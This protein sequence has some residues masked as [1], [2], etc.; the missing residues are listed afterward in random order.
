MFQCVM[1]MVRLSYSSFSRFLVYCSNIQVENPVAV[2][3]QEEAKKFL[4]GKPSDKYSFFLKA[5]ELERVDR[6]YSATMDTLEELMETQQKVTQSLAVSMERVD[7]LRQKYEQHRELE[8]LEYKVQELSLK[9]A[10]SIHGSHQERHESAL[11]KLSE[12]KEKAEAKQEELTQAEE[13]ANG[14]NDEGREKTQRIKDLSDE[15]G[16]QADLKRN[17]EAQLKETTLPLK[18][19]QRELSSFQK[20]HQQAN[21]AVADAKAK[22]QE[23]RE[24]LVRQSG[25]NESEEAQRAEALQAAEAELEEAKSIVDSLKQKFS[26]TRKAA[27]EAETRVTS[28]RQATRSVEQQLGSVER[29]LEGLEASGNNSM[30]VF[31]PRVTKVHKMIE[32]GKLS[33]IIRFYEKFVDLTN[34]V[35]IAKQR[36]MFRGPVEGP[37]GEFLKISAG[38]E[39]FA[40]IG[41]LALGSG[42]LDRFVV[43][44][45]A[46]RKLVQGIRRKCG[47]LQDCGIFQVHRSNS[48][49]NV[50]SPPVNGIETV[51][52]AFSIES[53]LIFNCLVDN[54]RIEKIALGRSKDDSQAKLLTTDANGRAA[55]RGGKI[56]Q[57]YFM[58]K[59]DMWQVRGGQ[60][61]LISNERRMR[62]T[63]S[64]DKSEAIAATKRE[65]EQLGIELDRATKEE[66][67]WEGEHNKLTKAWNDANRARRSNDK[68]MNDLIAQIDQIK[69]E[70]ENAVPNA[71]IDTS[72][73]EDGK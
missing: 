47:C 36:R 56:A 65:I 44:N 28:A 5:T 53:D 70:I 32:D 69:A 48:R 27:E 67:Q 59:G 9:Y 50:P 41:E 60:T 17:L 22:L 71:T 11:A 72:V 24:E 42:V 39:E 64:A 45:D 13:A 10:W 8:K 52:S 43:T 16:E 30:A 33:C 49:F 68:K 19:R 26:D 54:C 12:F 25:S 61:S 6:V 66:H 3:D 7:R 31:G 21:R 55:I 15:A 35:T 2:L 18:Q 40:E 20:R 14:P 38:K 46:D 62:K 23:V 4:Q 1:D 34:R 63:I 57:V 73:Y 58:P 29:R 37:I 51:A